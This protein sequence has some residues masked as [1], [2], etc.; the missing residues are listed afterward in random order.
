MTSHNELATGGNILIVDDNPV[1]VRT[2]TLLLS[3]AGYHVRV[4]TNGTQAIEL[5]QLDLPDLILLD[6]MMPDMDGY[7]VCQQLKADPHTRPVPIIFLS[8]LDMAEDKL[9]AFQVGGADYVT[10]PFHT[11]E[12]LARVQAHLAEY[13]GKTLLQQMNEQLQDQLREIQALQDRLREQA[14]RDALTGLFNRHYLQEMLDHHVANAQ[15]ETSL[16]SV[17]IIDIDHFK[18][19]NDT[20]GHSAGDRVLQ[21]FGA[22]LRRQTRQMDIACRYGGEEFVV[23]LPRASQT[24]AGKRVDEWRQTFSKIEVVTD[25]GNVSATFSAGIAEFPAH[26]TSGEM[27][28]RAADSALYAAKQAGRNRVCLFET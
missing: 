13:R 14:I 17:A 19:W 28:L 20:Y 10:K 26:G 2:L 18:Q 25:T 22:L 1:N 15:R 5:V 16:L 8:A 6:V 9:K 23:L 24:E 27:L 21:T 3:K 12:V 11:V 4:A 7:Q